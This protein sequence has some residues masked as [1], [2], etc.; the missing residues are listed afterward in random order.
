MH[1]VT[2]FAGLVCH[3]FG[4]AKAHSLF[5]FLHG[6]LRIATGKEWAY[7]MAA[8]S[9]NAPVRAVALVRPGYDDAQ[10]EVPESAQGAGM[11]QYTARNILHIARAIDEMKRTWNPVSTVGI[12]FSGGAACM[13]VLIGLKPRTVSHA[14]LVSGPLDVVEWRK[15]SKTG[16]PYPNS[17]SPVDYIGT[18]P[19]GTRIRCIHGTSDGLVPARFSK[20]YAE[21]AKAAGLDATYQPLPGV[22]HTPSGDIR[23]LGEAAIGA[24]RALGT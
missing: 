24:A 1:T 15:G 6:D 4:T 18:I 16:R 17:L 11:D 19:S 5:V 23:R 7:R 8:S 22:R 21:K 10:D 14:V 12:G 9:G 2:S 20:E 3:V 13:G